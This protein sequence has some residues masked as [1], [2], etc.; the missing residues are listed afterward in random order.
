MQLDMQERHSRLTNGDPEAPKWL[1]VFDVIVISVLL[2]PFNLAVFS[3]SL[4]TNLNSS[5]SAL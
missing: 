3:P 5:I 1:M 4:R 2:R